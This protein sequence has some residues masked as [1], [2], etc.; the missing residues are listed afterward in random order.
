M[1]AAVFP[2][3]AMSLSLRD[4]DSHSKS[5][6]AKRTLLEI[7]TGKSALHGWRRWCCCL[8]TLVTMTDRFQSPFLLSICQLPI[9]T[10]C[11]QINNWGVRICLPDGA[12]DDSDDFFEK[13]DREIAK[14]VT[15]RTGVVPGF[16]CAGDIPAGVSHG[17]RHETVGTLASPCRTG[18]MHASRTCGLS[19]ACRG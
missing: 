19:A 18:A 14:S 7:I 12:Q 15:W 5:Q 17:H 8:R 3:L 6:L 16:H 10:H 4:K 13:R 11:S 2:E 9:S 1:K